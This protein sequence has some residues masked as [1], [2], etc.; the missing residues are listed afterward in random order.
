MQLSSISH[1]LS[2]ALSFSLLFGLAVPV[3]ADG[4]PV[5][6]KGGLV[7]HLGCRNGE[8]T[9]QLADIEGRLIHGLDRDAAAVAAARK[10]IQAKGLFGKVS[11]SQ[12]AGSSLPYVDNV[13]NLMLVEDQGDISLGEIDR[14]LAPLGV[15]YIKDKAAWTKR[16]KPWPAEIDEWTHYLH[17]ATNNAV[18]D[19]A[20]GRAPASITSGS[21]GRN[22]R[23]A[24]ITFRQPAPS[25][26][27]PVGSSTSSM[28]ALTASVALDPQWS[29][30]ARDAFSGVLLW[31]R[32]IELWEGHLRDFR[33][34]P[35]DLA[36]RL[37]AVGD[38]VYVTLGYG[39]P[40]TALDAATGETVRTYGSVEGNAGNGLPP[41][42]CCTWSWATRFPKR[43]TAEEHSLRRE[44]IWHWWPIYPIELPGSS[45][46]RHRG[47]SGKVL[48]T[49]DDDQ[50]AEV[51]PTTLAVA[52]ESVFF[53]NYDQLVSLDAKTGKPICGQRTQGHRVRRPTW[54]TPTVVVYGDVVISADRAVAS[55][56][57]MAPPRRTSRWVVN[58]QGGT[59]P[60]G[61]MIAF[62]ADS[63]N[64]SGR[65]R[66]GNATTRRSTSW[67]PTAWSGRA[68]WSTP[69]TR[70]SPA[71]STSRR[72]KAGAVDRKTRNISESS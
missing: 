59:A 29:L 27:R 26:R 49:K 57:T 42:A 45:P 46:R 35:S 60:V 68:T 41:A 7:V 40:V 51:L 22:G 24:T 33:T 16:D 71:G 56:R 55:R 23:E 48:W 21:P 37:V 9:I 44:G 61:E 50:A 65:P 62:S 70:A 52:G 1:S 34:G 20:R 2:H 39:E 11:I 53:Q 43:S 14:V 19:D 58:S 54:S 8:Q 64:G 6:N 15:A 5:N 38:R 12:L 13:V 72:A 30:V 67:W 69:A 31:K 25:S 63:A 10:L 4:L 18:A 28:K 47:G 32:P 3:V 66:A 17:D 36:R